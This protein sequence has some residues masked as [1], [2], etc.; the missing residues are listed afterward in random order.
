[1]PDKRPLKFDHEATLDELAGVGKNR[2]FDEGIDDE[3]NE[4]IE[5]ICRRPNPTPENDNDC[6]IEV[7][8]EKPSRATRS[9]PE[10]RNAVL[11][12]REGVRN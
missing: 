9:L 5:V 10:S 3:E 12:L 7:P 6:F 11:R 1:M 2:R 4:N 8:L